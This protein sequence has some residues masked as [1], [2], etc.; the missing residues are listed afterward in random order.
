MVDGVP[1][2]LDDTPLSWITD[3]GTSPPSNEYLAWAGY[4]EYVREDK[5]GLTVGFST[6]KIPIHL[7]RRQL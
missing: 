6:Q 3:D 5:V 2:E 1:T 7:F 4:Y